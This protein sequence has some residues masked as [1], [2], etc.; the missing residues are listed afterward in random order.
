MFAFVPIDASKM[1]IQALYI[2]TTIYSN[3]NGQILF[4]FRLNVLLTKLAKNISIG[5]ILPGI[6]IENIC[7]LCQIGFRV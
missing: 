1:W 2:G 5:L 7:V 6:Y 4:M 3:S